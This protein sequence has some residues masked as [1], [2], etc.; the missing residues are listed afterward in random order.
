MS[1][2]AAFAN[3][4]AGQG[5]APLEANQVYAPVLCTATT[6]TTT[7]ATCTVFA[8]GSIGD[9]GE[10]VHSSDV[11]S[12]GLPAHGSAEELLNFRAGSIG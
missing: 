10:S 9:A 7:T 8:T 12:A 11:S 6:L 2:A 1:A 5:L 4:K 3:S